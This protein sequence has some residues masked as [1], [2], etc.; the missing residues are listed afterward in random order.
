MADPINRSIFR[1]YDIRG[2]FGKTLLPSYAAPIGAAYAQ[3][4]RAENPG[5]NELWAN[6]GYDGRLSTPQLLDGLLHG[7]LSQ[8]IR[9]RVIGQGPTPM[10]YFSVFHQNADGGIMITG[11][12]NPKDHN[13]FKM[14]IGKKS[15][16]GETIQ[17]LGAMVA[18]IDGARLPPSAGKPVYDDVLESYVAR[19]AQHFPQTAG[20]RAAWDAGNGAA[21]R[22]LPGLVRLLPGTH[23]V[24]NEQV[25][26]NF[27][28]HHPDPSVEDNMRQLQKTVLD[29]KL[30]VG[31]AFDGDGDRIGIVDN[32]GRIFWGDQILLL[33]A[34]DI[35]RRNPGAPVIGDVKCSQILFDGLSQLGAKP[36]IWK[37]G[38]SLIKSK[39]LELDAPLA[40]EMSGHMFIKDQYYGFD[41]GIY[42]AVRILRYLQESGTCLSDWRDHLPQIHNTPEIRIECADDRKFDV[43]REIQARLKQ[44]GTKFSD[45]DGVRVMT[46]QGWWVLR[47]S[48]TQPALALRAEAES[49]EALESLKRD[50]ERQLAASHVELR[51][52]GH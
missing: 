12:H 46:N 33:L 38:H 11:S 19:L 13:G 9:V 16:S 50:I 28:N 20:L 17:R 52:A 31:F 30:D 18:A 24:L 22:V 2:V 21:G 29:N 14:M 6:V 5:K 45:I 4:L 34:E 40:G 51:I 36:V 32:Q 1:E 8:N 25:D 44:E 3:M 27:P 42:A 49:P 15:L 37:T 43:I 47:A 26:G 48:N 23:I 39:M 10:L 41:D 7:L 35:A